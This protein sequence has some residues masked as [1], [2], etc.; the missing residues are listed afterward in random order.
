M[1][2][3]VIRS[4]DVVRCQRLPLLRRLKRLAIPASRRPAVPT[5]CARPLVASGPALA[6]PTISVTR[7]AGADPSACSI[8]SA[9]VGK[10][11]WAT[12]VRTR[13]SRLHAAIIRSVVSLTTR[14]RATVLRASLGIRS[15]HAR[16]YLSQPLLL[17]LPPLLIRAAP[18][19]AVCTAGVAMQGV[20]LSVPVSGGTRARPPTASQSVWSAPNVLRIG[21]APDR[22]VWTHV[23]VYVD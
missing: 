15:P 2:T 7:T 23:W 8:P 19:R 17:S 16:S 3:R 1:D 22:S 5:P 21:R 12:S 20:V 9:R 4:Q 6:C 13:A 11:V 10:R 18:H 14:L